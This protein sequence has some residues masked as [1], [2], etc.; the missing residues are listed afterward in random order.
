MDVTIVAK[1][2]PGTQHVTEWLATQAAVATNSLVPTTP[3]R[4]FIY[5]VV[6]RP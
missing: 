5:F 2:R 3:T 1:A 4:F 6:D